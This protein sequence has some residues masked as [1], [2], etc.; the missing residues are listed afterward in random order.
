MPGGGYLILLPNSDK[1]LCVLSVEKLDKVLSSDIEDDEFNLISLLKVYSK[2]YTRLQ[3]LMKEFSLTSKTTGA[4]KK[5]RIFLRTTICEVKT[6]LS[7]LDDL[8][9]HSNEYFISILEW[10]ACLLQSTCFSFFDEREKLIRILKVHG[11]DEIYD[12]EKHR[13]NI[14]S[15]A[16]SFE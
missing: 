3:R 5:K 2:Q 12:R 7:R 1:N 16:S 4:G 11:F 10:I 8:N 13:I 6:Y 15:K 14:R 9:I